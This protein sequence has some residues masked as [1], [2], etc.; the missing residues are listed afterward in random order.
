MSTLSQFGG[1]RATKSIVHNR[2][3][4]NPT[5]VANLGSLDG[6][7]E[8]LG[9]SM[10][11]ATLKTLLTISSGGEI[12]QLYAYSKDA[13]SRTIRCKVTLDGTVAFDVTSA[14][15]AAT[16]SGMIVVGINPGAASQL[17]FGPI[18]FNASCV[19]EVASSLTETDKVA[20]GYMA[21][22]F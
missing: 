10:T 20:I 13:T 7:K 12:P 5:A 18:K 22:T 9:G 1:N 17:P 21:Q 15:V 6:L 11:A 16:S 4:G 14:A 19:V 2:S 3:S 8:V